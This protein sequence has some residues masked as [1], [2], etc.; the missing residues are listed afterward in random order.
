[1]PAPPRLLLPSKGNFVAVVGDLSAVSLARRAY[2]FLSADMAALRLNV[3]WVHDTALYFS[4]HRNYEPLGIPSIMI[5]DTAMLR[6]SNSHTPGD[7]PETL[8]YNRMALVSRNIQRFVR[9]LVEGK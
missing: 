8:D 4:D 1:M 9:S 2:R 3:P 5:T 7:T 6:N